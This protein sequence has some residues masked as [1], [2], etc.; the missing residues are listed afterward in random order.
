MLISGN[1][2]EEEEI[3]GVWGA[4]VVHSPKIDNWEIKNDQIRFLLSS[5]FLMELK[6]NK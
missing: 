4:F 6:Q 1:G 3:L 5:P 2:I